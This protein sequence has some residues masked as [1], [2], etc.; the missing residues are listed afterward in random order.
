MLQIFDVYRLARLTSC[1]ASGG[2]ANTP[3]GCFPD[4]RSPQ[5]YLQVLL[6]ANGQYLSHV[7][8]SPFPPLELLLPE[9]L[10]R[11]SRAAKLGLGSRHRAS[12]DLL[13]ESVGR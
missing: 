1:Q 4:D 11:S 13:T 3:S 10:G 5:T 8:G 6:E 12:F 9:F 7:G 2:R